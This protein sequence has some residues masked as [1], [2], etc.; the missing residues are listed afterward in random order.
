MD[1]R[2]FLQGTIA[3]TLAALSLPIG[4]EPSRKPPHVL[5]ILVDDLG[6]T[7]LGCHGSSFYE[8]PNLDALADS[9]IRFTQ[10]YAASPVCSPTRASIMTGKYPTRFQITDW[11]P[12]QDPKDRWLRG[13]ETRLQ[14]PLEEIT[15]AE[16][17]RAHGYRTYYIGKWHL[18]GKGYDP[19]AQGFDDNK[20]GFEKG[21]PPGGYYSPYQNPKLEDGPEGE[22]LT[23]RLTD[24]C[25]R[26]LETADQG[27]MFIFLSFYT[28][29]TPIQACER[30]LS[31]FD[32]KWQAWI[33]SNKD[34]C[35]EVFRAEREG[36]TRLRQD[37]PKYAS[38]VF[39]MDENVGRLLA[40]IEALGLSN[41]IVVIF[42]SDNGGLSTLKKQ[43][44]PT[45]NEP[46]RA[47]KGWCYE[48]GIRVPL[49][50]RAPGVTRPGSVCHEPVISPDFYPTL[51]ELTGLPLLPEQH[52]DGVSMVPL[53]KKQSGGLDR[54]AIFW[55]YPHYHGS[56]WTP[57]AA[58]RAGDW[59]LIHFMEEERLELYD[60]ARD[61][62]E[63]MNQ[64]ARQPEKRDELM[65]LLRHWQRDTGALLPWKILF[66]G[67]NLDGWNV[68]G[69]AVWRVEEGSLWGG[70]DGDTSRSGLLL[71]EESFQDFELELEFMIDEHGK[72]NSGIYLRNDPHQAGWTGFQVNIGRAEAGEYCGLYHKDWLHKGDEL[73]EV[74]KKMDWNHY[75][76]L[77]RGARV[78]VFLNG[79]EIVDYEDPDPEPGLLQSGCIGLQ[80][81][82]AE[83]HDGWVRF[84]NIRIR[85]L[86]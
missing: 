52:E 53:L 45:S 16:T 12:G 1:R 64:E 4:A 70:Q 83:G 69:D 80:T 10:A 78:L 34:P 81:Y 19:E 22:Y 13:P 41:D 7:D 23:D 6:W 84:R 35:D 79:V 82:G 49:L 18:G 54:E 46:L 9:G 58:V 63:R 25:I 73:D 75:R 47:G 26:F 40:R 61:P 76:I 21:S 36:W 3:G 30:H 60:L 57:G 55:H 68:Q 39:A 32:R 66:N 48:G 59:K 65:G 15:L 50:M 11:I 72:Y 17:F 74:R 71:T 42:T 28:V 85:G 27:P 33:D 67:K 29:H 14:L 51:L 31:R 24:E 62:S 56:T 44:A 38:M 8:T 37:C 86:L 77:A 2:Q 5:F 43:A 20:G